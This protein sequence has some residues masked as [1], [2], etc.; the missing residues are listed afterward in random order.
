MHIVQDRPAVL[1]TL[2]IDPRKVVAAV[3]GLDTVNHVLGAA[4]SDE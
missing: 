3:L 4:P 2:T 1:L